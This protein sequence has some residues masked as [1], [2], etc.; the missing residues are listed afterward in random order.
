MNLILFRT[1]EVQRIIKG[2]NMNIFILG[3]SSVDCRRS[4]V[5]K[6]FSSYFHLAG[7]STLKGTDADVEARQ[8][9]DNS[10]LTIVTHYDFCPL[11]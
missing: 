5:K 6:D 3:F 2:L 4:S 10:D 7:G 8:E 1:H 9:T 11:L